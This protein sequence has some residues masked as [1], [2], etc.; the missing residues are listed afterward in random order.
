MRHDIRSA[1]LFQMYELEVCQI[2]DAIRPATVG[3]PVSDAGFDMGKH[4]K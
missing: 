4:C 2:R 3:L 1:P